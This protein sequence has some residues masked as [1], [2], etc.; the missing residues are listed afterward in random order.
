NAG[1][2]CLLT[3]SIP[4]NVQK[5]PVLDI[6]TNGA[7]CEGSDLMLSAENIVDDFD[8]AADSIVT[9]IWSYQGVVDSLANNQNQLIANATSAN[10]GVYQ[11]TGIS[12]AGCEATVTDTITIA[13]KPMSPELNIAPLRDSAC[14]GEEFMLIG[15]IDATAGITYNFAATPD[16]GNIIMPSDSNITSISFQE[17]GDYTISYW[18]DNNGCVSDTA[19]VDIFIGQSPNTE[20]TFVGATE[21]VNADSTLQLFETGGEATAWTWLRPDSTILSTEQNPILSADSVQNGQYV[22]I[23]SIGSCETRDTIEVNV[24]TSLMKPSIDTNLV[25]ACTTDTLMLSILEEYD[26]TIS[27]IWTSPDTNLIATPITTDTGYLEL[28]PMGMM[29]DSTVMTSMVM[30]QAIADAGCVSEVDT[31]Q[32]EIMEGPEVD[33]SQNLMDYTCISSDSLITLFD[34]AGEGDKYTWTGPC[35]FVGAGQTPSFLV[36]FDDAD[37]KSGVYKVFVNGENGCEATD[38]IDIQFTTGLPQLSIVGDSAYCEGEEI[39]LAVDTLF[40]DSLAIMW[41]GPEGFT[42]SDSIIRISAESFLMGEYTVT[43]LGDTTTCPSVISDPFF[44]TVLGA[45]VLTNDEFTV[46]VDQL[47]SLDVLAN[48][49]LLTAGSISFSVTTSPILGNASFLDNSDKLGYRSNEGEIGNDNFTYEVC[50]EGCQDPKAVLCAQA[51]VNVNVVFPPELCVVADFLTPNGDSKNDQFIVSC[52][53]AGEYP[54]NELIIFNEWGDEVFR[55]S[56]Y[57]N[58]WEGTYN[59]NELPDGTYFYIFIPEPGVDA[60]KGFI[61]LFR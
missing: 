35:D 58:D 21:C 41:E 49:S 24:S 19:T 15:T 43:L 54:N 17:A 47:D 23:A 5:T 40:T 22:L 10:S 13:S 46:V 20:L 16:T 52:A 1:D 8:A 50:Y 2:G 28:F 9:W 37:C 29:M 38:S 26:S 14:V 44:V 7:T 31:I 30:V 34:A 61:T 55:A 59:G 32:F 60:Q 53:E 45:P 42:S 36:N 25:F 6:I 27:F 48:D 12:A 56:P 51:I 57:N 11:V 3:G 4:L 18:V 39:V 33:L